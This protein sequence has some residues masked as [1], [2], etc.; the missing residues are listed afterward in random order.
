MLKTEAIEL[1]GGSPTA[2]ASAIGI[3]PQAVSQW[4][5][6]LPGRIADRVYAALARSRMERDKQPA[7]SLTKAG[8][9]AV[10]AVEAKA[11]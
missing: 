8:A 11:A 2:A 5:D 6:E 9:P 4:P 3:T 7:T 1:L 10:P